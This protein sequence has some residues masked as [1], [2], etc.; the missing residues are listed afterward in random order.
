L[1]VVALVV[2][3]SLEKLDKQDKADQEAAAFLV[4]LAD[5]RNGRRM[6][7]AW[8]MQ[9]RFWKLSA[10]LEALRGVQRQNDLE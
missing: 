2:V 8:G 4:V 10:K 6:V 3:D 7:E 9:L 1:A 5:N